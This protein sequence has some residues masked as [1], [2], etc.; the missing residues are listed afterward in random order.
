MLKKIFFAMS[1]IANSLAGKNYNTFAILATRSHTIV[2]P[3]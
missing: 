3:P 1:E 2:Y